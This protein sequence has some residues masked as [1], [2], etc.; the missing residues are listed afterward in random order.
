MLINKYV[1]NFGPFFSNLCFVVP[2]ILRL[3]RN[4]IWA[5]KRVLYFHVELCA[6]TFSYAKNF[7]IN[8]YLDIRRKEW[9]FV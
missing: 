4:F 3:A 1:N 8:Y 6:K 9:V 7:L 5:V 2:E